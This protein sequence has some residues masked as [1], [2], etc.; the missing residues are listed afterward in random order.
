MRVSS[1][2]AL[3][4][5]CTVL[6]ACHSYF[7]ARVEDVVPQERVRVTVSV[8]QAQELQTVLRGEVRSFSGTVVE[9]V[10]NGQVLLEVPL[11]TE[12]AGMSSAP[13]MNRVRLPLED[14][15]QVERRQFSRWKTGALLGVVGVAAGYVIYDAFK[16]ETA[17]PG[18][19]DRGEV[20]N[21]RIILFSLPI[22]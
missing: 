9:P 19:G 18:D 15:I 1:R 4:G 5:L 13:L 11:R 3:V 7:P 2:L 20:D 8:D 6:G 14:I 12:Q 10:A 16:A 21:Q 17:K 22:R